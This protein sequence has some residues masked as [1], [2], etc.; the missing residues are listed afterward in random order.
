MLQKSPGESNESRAED[1][2]TL[3]NEELMIIP[4]KDSPIS[5]DDTP[6]KQD[7]GS[8]KNEKKQTISEQ[9]QREII[10]ARRFNRWSRFAG[11]LLAIILG[12]AMLFDDAQENDATGV[13]LATGGFTT[14]GVDTKIGSR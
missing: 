10:N 4:G 13:L 8:N 14:L 12:G 6:P 2:R 5:Q 3:D 11:A 1:K 7:I 9:E